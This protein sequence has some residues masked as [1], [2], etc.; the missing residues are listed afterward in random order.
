MQ[1]LVTGGGGFVGQTTVAALKEA[2]H[3]VLIVGRKAGTKPLGYTANLLNRAERELMVKKTRADALVHLAWHTCPGN[4]WDAP[5]NTDWAHASHELIKHFF[6]A[7]GKR[8][9][10]AG[11][12]AE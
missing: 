2:G 8:A 4:F 9:V 3:N 10:L 1:I 7:G 6:D 11:S 5:D 12:C